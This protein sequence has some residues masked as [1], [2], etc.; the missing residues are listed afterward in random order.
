[1]AYSRYE[2]D[3]GI[4]CTLRYRAGLGRYIC[5]IGISNKRF[6]Y[7]PN[8]KNVRI[9]YNDYARQQTGKAAPKKYRDLLPLIAMDKFLQHQT[10]RYFQR[11]RHYGLHAGITYAKIKDQLPN[12]LKRNGQ[13]VRTVIQILGALLA[14]APYKCEYCGGDDFEYETV[15]VDRSYLARHVLHQGRSPPPGQVDTAETGEEFLSQCMR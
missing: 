9:E 3:R 12:K 4:P 15:D 6:H 10:P 14:E 7:D 11:V 5:R 1:M 13:T 8:G 2:S